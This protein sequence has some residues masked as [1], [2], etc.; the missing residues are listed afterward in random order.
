M[1]TTQR[2]DGGWPW[3][4]GAP[5]AFIREYEGTLLAALN[6]AQAPGDFAAEPA[7]QKAL[8]RAR[9]YFAKHTPTSAYSEAMLLWAATRLDGFADK[10]RQ[11]T[12]VER[13]LSLRAPDGG[14]GD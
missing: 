6:I 1:L 7:A 2:A 12:I 14:L 11:A 8:H 10:S 13:L 9:G 3:L 4:P 5:R